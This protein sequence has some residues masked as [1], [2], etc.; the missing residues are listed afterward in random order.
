MKKDKNHSVKPRSIVPVIGEYRHQYA[1]RIVA[2][3]IGYKD[4]RVLIVDNGDIL[5]FEDGKYVGITGEV[6]CNEVLIDGKAFKDVAYLRTTFCHGDKRQGL[7][8]LQ[9]NLSLQPSF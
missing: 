6:P 2:N 8:C 1:L 5:T 7:C 3:C 9:L 4:D